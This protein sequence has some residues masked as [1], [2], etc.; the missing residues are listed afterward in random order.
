[1]WIASS[2]SGVAGVWMPPLPWGSS[3]QRPTGAR[4]TTHF[5]IHAFPSRNDH[6]ILTLFRAVNLS[7]LCPL[8]LRT[9]SCSVSVL[10][11][12]LSPP[13]ACLRTPLLPPPLVFPSMNIASDSL[14][15]RLISVLHPFHPRVLFLQYN[16]SAHHPKFFPAFFC[17]NYLI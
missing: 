14:L 15:S 7:L 6:A 13:L 9:C 8:F 12:R 3:T 5:S 4:L 16:H 1:M 11:F 10:L 17:I 2:T